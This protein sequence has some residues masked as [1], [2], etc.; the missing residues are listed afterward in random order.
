MGCQQWHHMAKK[1]H[2]SPCFNHLDLTDKMVLLTVP[3]VSYDACTGANSILWPKESCHTLFQL[4][5]PNEQNDAIDDAVSI[6]WQ[7]CWFYWHHMTEK[8]RFTSFDHYPLINAVVSLTT[9]LTSQRYVQT[10]FRHFKTVKTYLDIKRHVYML[11][12]HMNIV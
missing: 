6:T 8:T 10:L 2:V 7:H 12:R 9:P 5:S 1:S 11:F 3:S 4:G